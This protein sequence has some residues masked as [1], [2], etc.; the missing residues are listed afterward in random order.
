MNQPFQIVAAHLAYGF[1]D[2]MLKAREA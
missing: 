1:A 2:A